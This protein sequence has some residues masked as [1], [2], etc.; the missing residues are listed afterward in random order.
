MPQYN[1]R[2]CNKFF[3]LTGFYYNHLYKHIKSNASDFEEDEIK[4]ATFH[5]SRRNE[6]KKKSY[7]KMKGIS[8]ENVKHKCNI[9]EFKT[10]NLLT[11]KIHLIGKH[12]VEQLINSGYEKN[13]ID[14]LIE[15]KEKRK[16]YQKNYQQNYQQKGPIALNK[17]TQN[18]IPY[19][20]PLAF[21][22]PLIKMF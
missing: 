10:H 18:H 6:I 3:N 9:C 17:P 15:E 5:N 21:A 11:I 13:Y 7:Y 8:N 16:I 20:I 4:L 2:F 22:I 12:T 1:C 14:K 19:L